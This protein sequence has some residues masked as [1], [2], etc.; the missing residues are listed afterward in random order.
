MSS[1]I[2]PFRVRGLLLVLM[3]PLLHLW[4][5]PV[6]AAEAQDC[7]PKC[8]TGYTCQAGTCV[9]LCSPP[10]GPGQECTAEGICSDSAR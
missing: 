8:R 7:F 1:M 3:L 2:G 6:Q 5:D 4:V 10:C 9:T